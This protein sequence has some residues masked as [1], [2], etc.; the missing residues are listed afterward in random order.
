MNILERIHESICDLALTGIKASF[1][2]LGRD[3]QSEILK[4][5]NEL[6]NLKLIS[7]TEEYIR[8][9][10]GKTDEKVELRDMIFGLVI[11]KVDV[12]T[13]LEVI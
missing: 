13:Y 4:I 12:E 7:T 1:I 10:Y 9:K 5:F 3:E 8:K 6:Q 2:K 11:I